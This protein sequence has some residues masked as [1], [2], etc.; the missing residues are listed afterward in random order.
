MSS[1]LANRPQGAPCIISFRSNLTSQHKAS[2]PSGLLQGLAD[3]G[4]T[5]PAHPITN[6]RLTWLQLLSRKI[7]SIV[8][9]VRLSGSSCGLLKNCYRRRKF[10]GPV[11]QAEVWS[12][13]VAQSIIGRLRQEVTRHPEWGKNGATCTPNYAIQC[14][15]GV[16]PASRMRAL[17]SATTGFSPKIPHYPYTIG[18][19][20]DRSEVFL[21]IG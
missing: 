21:L 15:L 6:I 20:E 8:P 4:T 2:A 17:Q 11:S 5:F 19:W 1:V 3:S 10:S 9:V 16:Y 13:T 18:V 7:T 14:Q 12:E